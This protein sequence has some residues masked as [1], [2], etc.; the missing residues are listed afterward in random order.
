MKKDKSVNLFD[1]MDSIE[2]SADWDAGL[3]KKISGA[4]RDSK[5][6]SYHKLI[7]FGVVIL[8]GI[9]LG[10]FMLIHFN[11][12]KTGNEE[13]YKKIGTEFLFKT[14]SSKY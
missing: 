14:E 9:N 8:M 7:L 2:P 4:K 3:M 6:P 5:D 10:A 13:K 1:S 11:N 12:G